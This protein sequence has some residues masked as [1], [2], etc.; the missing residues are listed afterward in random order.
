MWEPYIQST[1]AQVPAATTKIV[2]IR[3][4]NPV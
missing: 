4:T 2:R 3:V 1:L